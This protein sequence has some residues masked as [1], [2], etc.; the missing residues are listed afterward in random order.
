M[1]TVRMHQRLDRN[2]RQNIS[3]KQ[4]EWIECEIQSEKEM[5]KADGHRKTYSQSVL[6]EDL[7]KKM[8]KQRGKAVTIYFE[9]DVHEAIDKISKDNEL[10]L[11]S[12]VNT[13]IKNALNI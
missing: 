10:P 8:R 7:F 1:K 3:G 4:S 2:L 13:I 5:C 12:V 11:F 6:S 9:A